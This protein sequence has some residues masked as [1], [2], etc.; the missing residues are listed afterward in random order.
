MLT[1]KKPRNAGLSFD[2][3]VEPAGVEPASRHGNT[4]LSTCLAACLI[5]GKAPIRLQASTNLSSFIS[6]QCRNDHHDQS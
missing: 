2:A 3:F 5:F 1:N 4:M 6:S